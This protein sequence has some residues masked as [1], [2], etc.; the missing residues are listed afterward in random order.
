[1]VSIF[2]NVKIQLN[3][4]NH[5]KSMYLINQLPQWWPY[6][7]AVVSLD[8]SLGECRAVAYFNSYVILN[9][10]TY[11]PWMCLAIIIVDTIIPGPNFGSQWTCERCCFRFLIGY[12]CI[13]YNT[14]VHSIAE[15]NMNKLRRSSKVRGWGWK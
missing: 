13:I 14:C 11:L 8:H 15:D 4:C 6:L 5:E 1:M 3:T 7:L 12:V 2:V 9:L 10:P